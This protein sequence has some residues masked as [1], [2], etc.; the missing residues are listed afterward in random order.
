[1]IAVLREAVKDIIGETIAAIIYALNDHD[2]FLARRE[3]L[4][5]KL[6]N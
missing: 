5:C 3:P 1:M 6:E 4:P 2:D